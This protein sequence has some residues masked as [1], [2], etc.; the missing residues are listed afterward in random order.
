M[1]NSPPLPSVIR[2][3]HSPESPT[4]RSPPPF[5]ARSVGAGSGLNIATNCTIA[6]LYRGIKKGIQTAQPW[7]R[8]FTTGLPAT[9][10]PVISSTPSGF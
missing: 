6:Y 7:R 1:E 10:H 9:V 4:R 2:P 3:T 8:N 5:P